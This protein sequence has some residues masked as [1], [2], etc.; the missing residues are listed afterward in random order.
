MR[1]GIFGAGLLL[2]GLLC[3]PGRGRA[4]ASSPADDARALAV[5]H[6]GI[7]DAT[8]RLKAAFPLRAFGTPGLPHP[9]KFWGASLNET[10]A[11]S[12]LFPVENAVNPSFA[13]EVD[14]L[15]DNADPTPRTLKLAGSSRGITGTSG[16]GTYA[17]NGD[18]YAVKVSDLSG[19]LHVNDGVDGG[20]S[21]SVSQNL[22]R[23]LNVLGQVIGVGTLGDRI[24]AAR[25]A[26][27][28]ATLDALAPVL[29]ASDFATA[30]PFLTAHAW[31]DRNV[32]NP[33]PLS[34]LRASENPV[35]Y[36]RGSP[37][38]Y[39]TGTSVDS[40]GGPVHL[41]Q[42]LTTLNGIASTPEGATL[43][44]LDTLH[45]QWIEIVSRA[46]VNVN[47]A[48]REVL[49]ALLDGLR[50]VFVTERRRNNPRWKGDIMLSLRT[51]N[52]YRPRPFSTGDEIGFLV[53]TVPIVA[54][55]APAPGAE[56]SA[57][58]I[59]DEIIACRERRAS[60]NFNYANPVLWWAGPFRSWHQFSAFADALARPAGGPDPGVGLLDDHRPIHV[61]YEEEVDDPT[62]FGQLVPCEVA[63]LHAVQ[64]IA[65]VLKANFNPNLHLNELNPDANRYLRV[66]KTD[67][68]V[69]STEFCFLPTG[70]FEVDAVGRVVRPTD[71]ASDALA[72]ADNA[73]VA[74]ASARAVVRLYDLH[75]QTTQKDFY[76]GTLEPSDA[77]FPTNSRGVL[78]I[79]PEP[80]NGI[81]PGNLGAPGA[82]DNEWGGYVSLST[83]GSTWHG[84]TSK[85]KNTLVKTLDL[86]AQPEALATMHGHF[87]LDADLCDHVLPRHEIASRSLGVEDPVDNHPDVVGFDSW[88]TGGPYTPSQNAAHRL[89]RSFRRAAGTP[90]PAL[91]PY[92]PSDLRIDG[93]Y[94]ERN[95]APA[96]YAQ[97]NA[98]ALWKFSDEHANG[99]VSF[100]IKPSFFPEMTGKIRSL[101]DMSRFHSPCSQL[102][103]VWPFATMFVPSHYDYV[104]AETQGPKFWHNNMGQFEPAS[105][106][107]GSMQWHDDSS[108]TLPQAHQFGK[109][110]TGLNHR[111]PGHAL[112]ADK[113]S[114]LQGHQ[115]THVAF[116]WNLVQNDSAGVSSSLYVNGT[117]LFTKWSYIT[118]TGGWNEG[119]TRMYGFEKHST[120]EFNQMRLGGTSRIGPGPSTPAGYR[121]N[122][123]PDFT[124]DELYVW[125]D[126]ANGS[127]LAMWSRGRYASPI[128][129]SS[130]DEGRFL[131]APIS[132][133]PAP[134]STGVR[135]LGAAWTWTAEGVDSFTGDRQLFAHTSAAD[136]V[137]DLA[138]R[139]ELS[140][141]DG[142]TLYGPFADDG[143][144][145]VLDVGGSPAVLASPAAL[146]YRVHMRTLY[147]SFASV[148]L[149]TP[150]FDDVTLYWD[151]GRL[152][153]TVGSIQSQITTPSSGGGGGGGGG[154]G[155]GATGLE[156]VLLLLLLRRRIADSRRGR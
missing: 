111:G 107:F 40:V 4:A 47:T 151:D 143:Y 17:A 26:G 2:L 95:A 24:L 155:C 109:L 84:A 11:P 61:R 100:W 29:G 140:L 105:L 88:P 120:G 31:L 12:P 117:S 93:L 57:Y 149:A 106:W 36:Y 56:I 81:F 138:P 127:P 103:Y 1:R 3:L 146:R 123:S 71:G 19:R 53:E 10:T 118:M 97:T 125:K 102:I 15:P 150:V 153:A 78:E 129:E 55:L 91:T 33:V 86:P 156:A 27:G 54:S 152:D 76:A 135:L 122:H 87:T 34:A 58:A 98:A 131:S 51:Q 137:D 23:L 75:R 48:P 83:V 148:L 133:A 96:Y 43:F 37:P 85:A 92:P 154:G 141:L 116:A 112:H 72:A 49:V 108:L 94:A 90:D 60:A 147:G 9:W 114:P 145:P 44:G 119:H 28:Y 52:S 13:V 82:P 22:K 115:W 68:V 134:S 32:A 25:P 50:G 64:A 8:A 21:G 121:G 139:V 62:G 7:V 69:N 41:A 39:R 35:S 104:Q 124:Y 73:L 74:Q 79:G 132:L 5:A 126:P 80:D 77:G 42:G 99:M 46:P 14:G 144:S 20:P 113:P 6:A 110:T 30:R 101:W 65:D 67:L 130:S 89:G 142:V 63:R 38:I 66:D 70:Y 59:A 45:P 18:H 136:P 128:R 16:P